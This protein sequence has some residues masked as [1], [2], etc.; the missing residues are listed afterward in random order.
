MHTIIVRPGRRRRRG[1][2]AI[3]LKLP[4][5]RLA[6]GVGGAVTPDFLLPTLGRLSVKT[7][8][9]YMLC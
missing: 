4:D 9:T 6:D 2:T 5:P 7:S 1:D 3:S 8:T